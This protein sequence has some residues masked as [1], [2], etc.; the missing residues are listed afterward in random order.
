MKDLK[1]EYRENHIKKVIGN[2]NYDTI[3][4]VLPDMLS[5]K[6]LEQLKSKTPLLKTY[7]FDGINHYKRK[8]QNK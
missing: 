3:L 1:F 5:F 2:E 6:N 7:F 4:I 8:I